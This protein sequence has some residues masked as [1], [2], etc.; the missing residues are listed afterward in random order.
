MPTFTNPTDIARETLKTLATRRI[1]PTPEN[2]QAIYHE[3][4]GTAP[5]ARQPIGEQTL[6]LKSEGKGEANWAELI[7]EL[8][9][10]WDLKQSGVTASRKKEGLGRVLSNFAKDPALLHTKLQALVGS[11]GEKPA[12]QAG[13]PVDGPEPVE[14]AQASP[15]AATVETVSNVEISLAD[16][17]GALREMLALTIQT[18]VAP[19]LSQFPELSDEAI[20][21]ARQ[22]REARDSLAIQ[23]VAK[24]LKQFWIKLELRNDSDAQVLDGLV[25][26]LRLLVDNISELL[27]DDKWLVGQMAVIQDIISQ[28]LDSRV[29]Y[30]AE[31]SFKEVIFKQGNLKHSLMEA[32]TTIKNMMATFIDRMSEMSASTGE[33]HNKIESYAAAISKTEDINQLNLILGDLMK[34]T[35]GMQLD[36]IRSRDELALAHKQVKDAEEKIRQLEIELDQVSELV[37]EDHLTGTLN[38]R[39]MEDAFGRELSRADRLKAPLCVSLL[40]IDH[41][42]RLNDTYGHDAGDEALVHLVRVT[43]EALR[44]TDVI[45]RFGGEEFV[46]ILPDT[47]MDEAVKVMTRV[48]RHLTKNFFM[49]DNQ[50][51]LITF[52]AGV[53]LRN[54][55]EGSESMISR[56]DR[57]L[58]Q[59]KEAGRN[60]VVPAD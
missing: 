11:W 9:R 20:L 8:I 46:I 56:A 6:P 2:Y 50:R 4:A 3:I 30:D 40:D 44:P 28:P 31:R 58:Y 14:D 19:R 49:H 16:V 42:K 33:Y 52:S 55:G 25:Q 34:D 21:L 45:A 35:R 36:M 60:R 48:Q 43:R 22:V 24:K 10:Q 12:A 23:G 5:P 54:A 18:G 38:R 26:L 57:A 51:L 37:H 27:L 29:L 39:G 1:A 15:V 32:R 41:F 59:A 47:G 53:A 7:R 13:V 17:P